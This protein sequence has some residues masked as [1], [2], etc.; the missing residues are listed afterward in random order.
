MIKFPAELKYSKEDTWVRIEGDEAR[1]GITE[2][3]QSQL[4][5]IFYVQLPLIGRNIKK[6]KVFGS[7]ESF[8]TT[9]DL[10]MPVSGEVLEV[11]QG[12]S[13]KPDFVNT[14]SYTK[15]WMIKIRL[16]NAQETVSLMDAETYKTFIAQKDPGKPKRSG[17]KNKAHR[18]S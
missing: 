15:G 13:T 10:F 6:D 14:A 11:N 1:M 9:S 5:E 2:F 8:K 17:D 7:L 18:S 16:T 12:L 4:G 3:F